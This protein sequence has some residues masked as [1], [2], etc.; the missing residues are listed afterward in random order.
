MKLLTGPMLLLSMLLLS[1]LS[2]VSGQHCDYELNQ[3]AQCQP[4]QNSICRKVGYNKTSLPNLFNHSTQREAELFLSRM[5]AILETSCSMYLSHFLC[6]A[7]Y[8]LCFP[9]HFQQVQPCKELCIAVRE[10]CVPVL[11]LRGLE[12]PQ[13]L[14]CTL[15]QS[16]QNSLCVWTQTRPCLTVENPSIQDN[17]KSGNRASVNCSGRLVKMDNS[18]SAEFGGVQH[19]AEPCSGVYFDKDQQN[20]LLI[21]ITAFSL[22]TLVVCVVVL[23]TFILNFRKVPYL[24]TPIYYI[25]ACYGLAS[26]VYIISISVDSESIICDTG[27]KNQ[28]NESAL[29]NNPTNHPLCLIMFCVFYYCILCSWSWW[30]ICTFQWLVTALNPTNMT[31]KWRICFHIIAWCTPL[32]F[33]L[34]A[35]SLGH[36]SGDTTLK[37]C[38]IQKHYELPFLV[39]PLS[40]AVFLCS[41]ILVTCFALVVKLQK[42]KK[43][44]S[45][46]A[47]VS[48]VSA[49]TLVRVGLYC[50]VYLVPMGLLLCVYFYE[51]WY[52]GEWEE[53]YL[54]C[55]T[56]S[57]CRK[58]S[59]P[60]FEIFVMKTVV[61]LSMGILSVLWIL[62]QDFVRAWK[63]VCCFCSANVPQQSGIY[64]PNRNRKYITTFQLGHSME[65][66]TSSDSSI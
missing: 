10:T 49:L 15:Y 42:L 59:S 43:L 63:K 18:S 33:T 14:D 56:T 36:V 41:V 20:I 11:Q 66:P 24:E 25:A 31:T 8:P 29:L 6:S 5:T 53:Q 64:S 26:L 61:S 9:K 2:L 7:T 34:T 46:D 58:S 28:F 39:A 30:V 16:Y 40:I 38:W 52:R 47:N 65:Y 17:K 44:T 48:R 3:N 60:V 35:L 50:T 13:E 55:T 22:I 21:W 37:T 45:S 51:F 54:E 4:V 12:W 23:L 32:V 57:N 27:F 19:C 62:G 1:S